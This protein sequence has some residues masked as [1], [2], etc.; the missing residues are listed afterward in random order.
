MTRSAKASEMR[1]RKSSAFNKELTPRAG[2]RRERDNRD[3]RL[4]NKKVRKGGRHN[5]DGT[6]ISRF[7]DVLNWSASKVQ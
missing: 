1:P 7:G 6:R 3:G 5:P 2:L 4:R